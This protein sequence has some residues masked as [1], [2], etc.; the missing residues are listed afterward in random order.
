[1]TIIQRLYQRRTWDF[2]GV[3][4]VGHRKILQGALDA[5][6]YNFWPI[7]VH[8]GKRVPVGVADL[9]RFAAQID[10]KTGHAH[11]HNPVSGEVGHLLGMPVADPQAMVAGQTDVHVKVKLHEVREVVGSATSDQPETRQAALGLY[12]LPTGQFPA[13]RVE[14][15]ANCF[16]NPDL[17]REV[18]LAEGAHAVD[19]GALTE[20]QRTA[21]ESLFDYTGSGTKPEGWFEEMGEETYW[22]WRGERWMGL[23][24]AAAAPGL[25][26]PLE[27]RQPW[28]WT[29]DASDVR[30][31][32]DILGLR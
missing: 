25:T 8:T 4:N 11:I 18:F 14:I 24:M 9:S 1:M 17:A 22:R 6:E 13:G 31:A 20:E 27:Q 30:R 10:P 2:N 3:P 29:Y 15:D 23:F 12:W 32:R 26:R 21:I 28:Q 5:C 7:R 16:T 19:Y